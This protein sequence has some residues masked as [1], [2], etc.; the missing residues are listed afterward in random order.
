MTSAGTLKVLYDLAKFPNAG[1]APVFS[2]LHICYAVLVIG[3]CGPK[4]RLE[5]SR[6]LGVGEGTIRTI[7]RRL[8]KAGIIT[9]GEEGCRLTRRGVTIYNRLRDKLSRVQAVDADE[10]SLDKA[11]AAIA[12]RS[13]GGLV[14]HG[15]EQRD[16]AVRAGATGACTLIYRNG[17]YLMPRRN[18]DSKLNPHDKLPKILDSLFAPTDNDVLI[19]A[20]APEKVVAE[21]GAIAA[22][23]TLME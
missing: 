1:P 16:A 20:S 22:A 21:Y 14:K 23:L 9:T 8:T 19:I 13:T 6:E 4:G 5:L 7:I 10:L 11:S 12:V 3:D 15:V 2:H 18:S 17:T